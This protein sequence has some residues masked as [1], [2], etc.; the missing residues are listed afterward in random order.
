ML[1]VPDGWTLEWRPLA[2]HR[3]GEISWP[4]RTIVI[5][6]TRSPESQRCTLTHEVIH[7]ERGPV[8]GD[9]VLIAREEHAVEEETARRL[10]G[11]DE[12]ADTLAWTHNLPEAADELGVDT[13][14]LRAR[15]DRLRPG[16]RAW[17]TRR[18]DGD[19]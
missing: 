16:E 12:L 10:I 9:P 8:L 3:T 11:I 14:T 19:R 18:L 6:P 5:D 13:H 15:L 1:Q 2:G 7:A 4:N 17:L